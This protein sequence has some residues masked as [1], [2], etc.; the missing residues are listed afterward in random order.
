MDKLMRFNPEPFGPEL[1]F[2]GFLHDGGSNSEFEGEYRGRRGYTRTPVSRFA[3]YGMSPR[4]S[5]RQPTKPA[6]PRS[7]AALRYGQKPLPKPHRHRRRRYSPG[8]AQWPWDPAWSIDVS[9]AG[10]SRFV[11]WIQSSL[12][13]AL[14][15]RLPIDGIMS[16]S[17]R[18]A[19]RLF[20]ERNGLPVTGSVDAQ[21]ESVLKQAGDGGRA[22]ASS[23][24]S[25]VSAPVPAGE[26]APADEPAARALAD[27]GAGPGEFEAELD[28]YHP[29]TAFRRKAPEGSTVGQQAV[30]I[31][32][33]EFARWNNGKMQETDPR[34]VAILQDY[35][36]AGPGISYSTTQLG[37]KTFQ[38]SH[39]WSAAFISWVMRKAGAAN[40]FRYSASHS[41][42]IVAAKNNR[43]ANNSNPFKAYRI[44]EAAPKVGDLVCKSRA[45]SGATYD[46]IRSGMT[47]HCDIVTEVK[48]GSIGVIGGNV[49]QSV[50][51]KIVP[52]DASGRITARDYFAVIRVGGSG[53]IPSAP[54]PGPALGPARSPQPIPLP[55][56]AV[57][58]VLKQESTPQRAT[59]YAKI[60]LGIT[61]R[62]GINAP[63]ITGIFVPDGFVSGPTV[64]VVLWLH[65]FKGEANRR[66]S[67]DQYW[68]ASRFA[69]GAFRE[70][71]N[72]SGRNVILVAPTLG[73][74]SEAG[75]LLKP[76]G[77]DTYLAKV[78]GVLGKGVPSGLGNLILACHSGGGK[79]MRALASGADKALANLR[80]CWGF[81]CT[82]NSG[83]DD[84]WAKWARGRPGARCYFYYIRNSPTARLSEA[85]RDKHVPN[86][87]VLPSK[88]NRHNYV[89]IIHWRERLQGAGFLRALSGPIPTP[90]TPP[91][92]PVPS[93]EPSDLKSLTHAQFI[94]FVGSRARNAMAA[95]GVPASVTVAQAILETGWGKHT[96]GPAK[97]L[98]GIKG[99]GP[100]GSI[101]VPTREFV[102]G[103][104]ITVQ[105]NFAKYHSFEQSITEHARFFLRNKR[106][107]KA[108]AVKN[109]AESFAREIH[110]AGYATGPTYANDLISLMRRHNLARFD[111][112]H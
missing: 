7:A 32:R 19:I 82:Y 16:A 1:E 96:I 85:L 55:G 101:S 108:L 49:N 67:I 37:S 22:A 5:F 76:G 14:R 89:P 31:A 80:E 62:F 11:E 2:E 79:P 27:T 91:G 58:T 29:L 99:K 45:G 30:Q 56:V 60:D 100:A 35:W 64:D 4:T 42:Y 20:Q 92:P 109:D 105:A 10:P 43:L 87:I 21:T 54:A 52:T 26:P 72:A 12:N 28:M 53:G 59:L 17:V 3:R 25:P 111:L 70:G 112:T 83:D 9:G 36:K 51:R 38:A 18:A 95:T 66:L 97:N 41:N 40:D 73:S 94:E 110:R 23:G 44:S 103:R 88:D 68:N 46:T 50:A 75:D 24:P 47:T 78:L 65:G 84:F 77:L 15:L 69:Y 39:P 48:P 8:Y 6:A 63:A 61:D 90:P 81:D 104:W 102:N 106:Y 57:P 34:A 107:A 13:T 74:R 98:F 71:V 93:G 33:N 86:A